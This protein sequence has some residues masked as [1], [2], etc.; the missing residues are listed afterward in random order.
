MD[1]LFTAT[2]KSKRKGR[3]MATRGRPRK[4]GLQPGWML[5]RRVLVLHSFNEARRNGEKYE[6]AILEA[7]KA[8]K[9]RFPDMRIG[10]R[11]VK[12]IL[13]EWQPK[14]SARTLTVSRI[15]ESDLQSPEMQRNFE[16][17]QSMGWPKE[18][19]GQIFTI[20]INPRPEYPRNNSKH[21]EGT[22]KERQ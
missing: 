18:K 2:V 22:S 8:V 13:A 14:R 19:I 10:P 21:P 5:E 15:S 9:A 4:N 20:G 3:A 12:G 11:R 6:V 16:V 1:A 17:L 7:I